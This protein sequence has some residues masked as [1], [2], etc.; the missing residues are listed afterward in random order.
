MA[1]APVRI[2]SVAPSPSRP[3]G[4]ANG[5]RPRVVRVRIPGRVRME[6]EPVGVP[7]LAANECA[8]YGVVIVPPALRSRTMNQERSWPRPETGR[9]PRG[10]EHRALRRPH[11][12]GPADWRR[13]LLRKQPSAV[14]RL[15][16]STP[17]LSARGCAI[18]PGDGTRPEPGRASPPCRF[19][20]C[21]IRWLVAHLVRAAV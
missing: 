2:W 16:G 12:E 4:R 17:G 13:H 21:R 18:R 5:S 10:Y 9:Y 20:S 14:R 3:T 7:G 15:P 1:V 6:S 8:P 19:D 11:V